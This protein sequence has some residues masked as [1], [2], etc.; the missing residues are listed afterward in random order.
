MP[1]ARVILLLAAAAFTSSATMRITDAM[2]P[3][4]ARS[5]ATTL[6]DAAR[7]VSWYSLAYGVM[8]LAMGA[9]GERFGKFRI[10]TA[11][12]CACCLGSLIS[13]AAMSLDQLVAA[14]V[15]A[16]CAA[17]GII[18]MSLAWLGDRVPYAQRQVTLARLSSGTTFGLTSGQLFGGL[19]TD[20]LGWRWAFVL[21]AVSYFVVGSLLLREARRQPLALQPRQASFLRQIVGVMRSPW[22]VLV[23]LISMAECAAVFAVLAL[24]PS[25]LHARLGMPLAAAGAAVAVFGLG[26][27]FYTL[28]ARRFVPLLGEAR[29]SAG[30]GLV[31]GAALVT[32]GMTDSG[33]VASGACLVAGFGFYML[34]NT[35][36]T[37]A[38]Q[39]SAEARG[40]A[41]A[42]FATLVF[43][44]QAGGVAIG[45]WMVG[46]F[47]PRS[48]IFTG[49]LLLAALGLSFGLALR[50]RAR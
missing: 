14:R 41:V 45:A 31:L 3:E 9:L 38:T 29:L 50:R 18:P 33:W 37:H 42:L 27:L 12:T 28:M 2:L 19:F 48:V 13:A 4:L 43:F 22:A 25:Y 30:G 10:I 7:V 17:A 1:S 11:A 49:A 15:L 46:A 40:T 26:A 32:L 44:G 39:L 34:H 5:Y 36:Q 8:Q 20:T 23:L 35:L 6:A 16:A 21:L 24:T 47:G